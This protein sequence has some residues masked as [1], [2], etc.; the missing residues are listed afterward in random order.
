MRRFF[1]ALAVVVAA[2]FQAASPQARASEPAPDLTL[3]GEVGFKDLHHYIEVPFE[4]PAG[5]E[6]LTVDFSQDGAAQRTTIDLGLFDPAR[7]RGW[8]GGNK[9]SFTLGLA[10]ATPSYLPGPVPAGRW[11]L[12]L[13]VPN[14]RPG[15]TSRYVAK[16]YFRRPGDAPPVSSFS[17]A[18]LRNGSGWYRG[19]LH[20]HTGHSDG[21][22]LSRAGARVACP[23]FLTLE[24]AD[25]RGLDFL[26]VTDHNTI[27][28]YD[29]LRELQPYF[30]RTLIIPGRELTTFEGHANAF[31]G[32]GFIDFRLDGQH[33]R[34]ADE[35]IAAVHREGGL[36]SINHP[37]APSGEACMGCGWTAPVADPS[38]IDAVE[39]V[40]GGTVRETGEA[41]G[42]GSGFAFWEGLLNHGLHPTAV[43]G[44][45][46]HDAGL[47]PDRGLGTPTTVVFAQ[48]L[49][50]RA[51]LDGIKAG[52]VFIDVQGSRDRRV[53]LELKVDGRTAM[54]GDRVPLA[55]GE[56]AQLQAQV[57]GVAGG[58]IEL[59]GDAG[60]RLAAPAEAPLTTDASRSWP[61]VADGARHWVFAEVRDATGRLVLISN[62]IYLTRTSK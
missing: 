58:R 18:P 34:T 26:V 25:R 15:V 2:A 24:A 17:D 29:A 36:F 50:E 5:V 57:L 1:A 55:R 37:G 59:V 61:L 23:T 6:R 56:A 53:E 12:L 60:L 13:G 43:A 16:I 4:V 39:V 22:C 27:S 31:G 46:N 11:R 35:L 49:S 19:D 8:S 10:D 51:I 42:P 28:H 32:L 30:D 38:R 47:P 62:P 41:D 7:F 44:S 33:V 48:A 14:I 21:R 3:S 52:H 20:D 9:S 54:M 40:N 45:D